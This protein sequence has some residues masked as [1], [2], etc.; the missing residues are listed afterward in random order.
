M[1][2]GQKSPHGTDIRRVVREYALDDGTRVDLVARQ[3]LLQRDAVDD[4]PG[5]EVEE[6]AVEHELPLAIGNNLDQPV[7]QPCELGIREVGP[8]APSHPLV[9]TIEPLAKMYIGNH[10][11]MAHPF[12]VGP[13]TDRSQPQIRHL[14]WL[15]AARVG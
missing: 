5:V 6:I 4:S 14:S 13:V 8:T 15:A 10:Y 12:I 9:V 2:V 7:Y 3:I 1:P 11:G